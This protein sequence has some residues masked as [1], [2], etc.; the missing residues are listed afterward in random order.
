MTRSDE[1]LKMIVEHFIR[2]AQPVGSKTLLAAYKL[3]YSSA[4][5]RNEMNALEQE[6]FLE[7]V[8]TSSGRVPSKKGYEYYVDHLR[9][10]SVDDQVKFALQKVLNVKTKS[11]E[12]VI[13]EA[14]EILSHMTNLASIVL[15]PK[16]QEEHLVSLQII[17]IGKNTATAV[18]VTDK[19]YVENKT[20]I[21]GPTMKIEDVIKSVGL[22][23]ERLKGTPIGELVPKMEAM[24]LVLTDYIVGHDVLYQAIL[25]AFVKFTTERLNLYGEE[26]LLDQPEFAND[27]KKLK[28]ILEALDDPQVLRRL[29]SGDPSSSNNGIEIHLGTKKDGMEDIAI[30]SAGLKVP[31]SQDTS[32]SVL[33]PTRMDYE[34]VMSMLE[35]VTGELETYF[36]EKED[37]G[38][39]TCSK[40]K[41]TSKAEKSSQNQNQPIPN[42]GP[43][44]MNLPS[45]VEAKKNLPQLTP[46][47][48]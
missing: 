17:P 13:K 30:V 28:R 14:C 48:K 19:G 5:I 31:G 33:G 25:E 16:V 26:S 46:E 41:T 45:Q 37:G 15:G 38:Q 20:F 2:T 36:Q 24:K 32:I 39:K 6:G 47:K 8:H 35:Y 43:S 11:V 1:I 3:D 21:I 44:K 4:T 10:S 7:K 22:L 23:S 27:T 29:M 40:T 42:R 12:E 18:F 9:S 34:K